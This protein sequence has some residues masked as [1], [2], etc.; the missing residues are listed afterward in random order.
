MQSPP[1]VHGSPAW[2]CEHASEKPFG[3]TTT[4]HVPAPFSHGVPVARHV[5]HWLTIPAAVMKSS[6]V[7]CEQGASLAHT[8]PTLPC[9]HT[10]PGEGATTSTQRPVCSQTSP[11]LAQ[12]A[13]PPAP[14]LPPA[15]P[16]PPAPPAPPAPLVDPVDSEAGG[17]EMDE[18]GLDS[19]RLLQPKA[20]IAVRKKI[21]RRTAEPYDPASK[22]ARFRP[23]DRRSI[24]EG[25]GRGRRNKMSATTRPASV[26]LPASAG[27]G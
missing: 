26:A 17:L 16:E 14:P 10:M 15:P 24:Q 13:E 20:V 4:T 19:S 7:P 27:V 2:P 11:G 18:K 9:E 1:L 25:R 21:S 5:V 23:N 12:G 3:E 6:Q 22:R 8:S